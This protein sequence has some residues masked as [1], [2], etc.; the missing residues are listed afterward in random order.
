MHS[1]L[2][3]H[4]LFFSLSLAPSHH[5]QPTCAESSSRTWAA[6]GSGC[7]LSATS[8]S[9][10]IKLRCTFGSSPCSSGGIKSC[11]TPFRISL[12]RWARRLSFCMGCN[13]G[14]RRVD[15]DVLPRREA[16]VGRSSAESSPPRGAQTKS[17]HFSQTKLSLKRLRRRACKI[18]CEN[19]PFPRARKVV[20]LGQ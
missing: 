8:F 14:G 9:A 2:E 17:G 1:V 19:A 11:R 4:A 6:C 7:F 10:G 12:R 13:G 5:S 18:A 16:V 3:R 15:R 20:V